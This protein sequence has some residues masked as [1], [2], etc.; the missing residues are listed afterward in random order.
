MGVSGGQGLVG[1]ETIIICH[2]Q[3]VGKALIG[4]ILFYK[5]PVSLASFNLLVQ[6]N[7]YSYFAFVDHYQAQIS[8][9]E[10][11]ATIAEVQTITIEQSI[12]NEANFVHQNISL[13]IA[14]EETGD[15]DPALSSFFK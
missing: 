12:R 14:E 3:T 9:E 15:Q 11:A 7:N 10:M 8:R 2:V 5:R 1:F 13:E 4:S 6:V